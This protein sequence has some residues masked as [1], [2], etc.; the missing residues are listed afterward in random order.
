MNTSDINKLLEKYFEAETTTAEEDILKE[1]FNGEVAPE[2]EK[3]KSYFVFLIKE[4]DVKYPEKVKKSR[5]GYLKYAAAAIILISATIT[6]FY[7]NR[8]MEIA[9][10]RETTREALMILAN[11]LNKVNI[12]LEKLSVIEENLSH[13]QDINRIQMPKILISNNLQG[14]RYEKDY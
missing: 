8:Q 11:N 13:L 12:E 9:E 7:V 6:G 2:L 10:E 1:Y 5:F 4:N 3:Y 14:F